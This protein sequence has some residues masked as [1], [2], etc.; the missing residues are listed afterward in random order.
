MQLTHPSYP[1][2]PL[3]FTAKISILFFCIVFLFKANSWAQTAK[4]EN[5]DSLKRDLLKISNDSF[6]A[7]KLL[8][9]ATAYNAI[10]PNKAIEFAYKAWVM[11]KKVNW[12]VGEGIA[13][14]TLGEIYRQ[15]KA[16]DS[17][18]YYFTKAIN[19]YKSI[20]NKYG[21]AANYNNIGK[22]WGE[23]RMNYDKVLSAFKEALKIYET[24]GDRW[25]IG[26]LNRNIGVV[27]YLMEDYV[28]AAKYNLQG[29]AISE[30]LRD[31]INILGAYANLIE[32]MKKTKDYTKAIAYLEKN[33][34]LNSARGIDVEDSLSFADIY[35]EQKQYK[36]AIK[37]LEK[38]LKM[39]E[40]KGIKEKI[41]N[42]KQS[43]TK[44]YGGNH[45]Y[46]PAM[47]MALDVLQ[48]CKE[49]DMT[50]IS[51]YLPEQWAKYIASW[52]RC[53]WKSCL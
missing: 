9:V 39:A 22:L 45:D 52:H 8:A 48:L 3:L 25:L 4:K 10:E 18:E 32:V 13:F 36:R 34:A 17:S 37:L 30:P 46:I 21:M 42:R 33:T 23:K 29:L 20:D 50:G 51:L 24:V 27:S 44:A 49:I 26:R 12:P 11:S 47:R 14:S 28:N 7:K 35:I 16:A 6:Y 40:Q 5:I 53:R 41:F 15:K 1:L 2:K 43:L 31:T 19:V 38:S